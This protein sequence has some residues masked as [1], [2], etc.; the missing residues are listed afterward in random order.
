MKKI[1][2]IDAAKLTGKLLKYNSISL[3]I[4]IILILF[5]S[6]SFFTWYYSK[7]IFSDYF[8]WFAIPF[9]LFFSI[10]VH[11]AR[12][13]FAL[14]GAYDQ[15]RGNSEGVKWGFGVSGFLTI[16]QLVEIVK[17][18]TDIA[19]DG[20]IFSFLLV[21]VTMVLLPFICEIRLVLT[22]ANQVKADNIKES[23]TDE[24]GKVDFTLLDRADKIKYISQIY[25][26]LESRLER[27]PK[28][29]ELSKETGLANSTISKYLNK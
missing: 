4:T 21:A 28:L 18:A 23:I 13:S 9:S 15:N 24:S 5:V 3:I 1:L 2:S 26:L 11:I 27:K 14:S 12:F 17:S 19:P 22:M 7:S 29:K 25:E 16:V 6:L 8:G 20:K 10:A